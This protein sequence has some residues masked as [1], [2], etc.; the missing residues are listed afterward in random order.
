VTQQQAAEEFAGYRPRLLGIAYRLLGSAWDAEDVVEDAAVK[1][2]SIDRAAI[3]RPI[4]FLTTMVTRLALDQLRSARVQRETYYGPWLPE[5][6]AT[7]AGAVGPL[8]TVE[9]RESLSLATMR[10]MERLT[11]PER[12]VFVLRTAFDMPYDE[13]A[14]VLDVT[15]DNAR[16]L[17]HRAQARVLEEPRFD[18]DAGRHAHLFARLVAATQSGDLAALEKLLADDVVAYND[19]GGK[20]RAAPVPVRGAD[21]VLRFIAGI[22]TRLG[23]VPQVEIVE[24]NGHPGAIL[25]SGDLTQIVGISVRDGQISEI[26]S[27]LNPDKLRYAQVQLRR[28]EGFG[29]L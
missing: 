5:P 14:A 29:A 7:S 3:D 25:T 9:Q 21:K 12:G 1:W 28:D 2:L 16:Q 6:L 24:F 20:T 10:M 13:I 23:G 11:P 27:V 22:L 17:H 15:I 19:G 8:D 26:Y 4:A 18:A